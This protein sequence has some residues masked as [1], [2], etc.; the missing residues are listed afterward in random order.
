LGAGTEGPD[1]R[2]V[3]KSRW[4]PS[5]PTWSIAPRRRA[6]PSWPRSSLTPVS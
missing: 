4:L 1:L 2:R 6:R 3:G 5:C